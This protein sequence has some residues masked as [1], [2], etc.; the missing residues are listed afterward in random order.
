M[1]NLID[2]CIDSRLYK[3]LMRIE[4]TLIHNV[5]QCSDLFRRAMS[6]IAQMWGMRGLKA[7]LQSENIRNEL[8]DMLQH[9][10][11]FLTF[12]EDAF[13]GVNVTCKLKMGLIGGM[14][15]EIEMAGGLED[16]T[17]V[18]AQWDYRAGLKP[19]WSHQRK[20]EFTLFC[21]IAVETT[22]VG[23]IYVNDYY[24]KLLFR[25]NSTLSEAMNDNPLYK[26]H[27]DML[28]NILRNTR[29]KK[30]TNLMRFQDLYH[31]QELTR[32][33]KIAQYVVLLNT[34]VGETLL[35]PEDAWMHVFPEAITTP[36][37]AIPAAAVETSETDLE[38]L[39]KTV[40]AVSDRAITTPYIAISG[41]DP[42]TTLQDAAAE[43][44]MICEHIGL[45]YSIGM[46]D[47]GL[48]REFW[49]SHREGVQHTI[50]THVVELD[51]PNTFREFPNAGEF[52]LIYTAYGGKRIHKLCSSMCPNRCDGTKRMEYTI[53]PTELDP[54]QVSQCIP[55]LYMRGCPS[56]ATTLVLMHSTL[57][58]Y[59]NWVSVTK[60]MRPMMVLT[61]LWEG[62]VCSPRSQRKGDVTQVIH[63]V[64][65]LIQND[66]KIVDITNQLRQSMGYNHYNGVNIA[67]F[68]WTCDTDNKS[69]QHPIPIDS[70]PFQEQRVIIIRGI[71]PDCQTTL[72]LMTVA[73]SYINLKSVISV[74]WSVLNPVHG[75]FL[76]LM[77]ENVL[78]RGLDASDARL[79][80]FSVCDSFGSTLTIRDEQ[81][82]G[83]AE[84]KHKHSQICSI[85]AYNERNNQLVVKDR[86]TPVK[87]RYTE[88]VKFSPE[89]SK[90]QIQVAELTQVATV[91]VKKVEQMELTVAENQKGLGAMGDV[92][93]KINND[94]T[95][96]HN[97]IAS[98]SERLNQV[99]TQSNQLSDSL[100][101][102][103]DNQ[104][105]MMTNFF[106]QL[107][108]QSD[109]EQLR[110]DEL[111]RIIESNAR[112]NDRKVSAR[113]ASKRRERVRRSAGGIIL[114]SETDSIASTVVE[115]RQPA[116]RCDD[117][118][119]M[120]E[121]DAESR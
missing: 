98:L 27:F 55:L 54:D 60:L 34:A 88:V 79:R 26:R 23:A 52:F 94:L 119:S 29:I 4:S 64:L 17:M 30:P 115:M 13:R 61:S 89:M 101:V 16:E 92:V 20:F 93:A 85:P 31:N 75:H 38:K 1:R 14:E 44:C 102:Q 95:L 22:E 39:T 68:R 66:D 3:E 32:E 46:I 10:T 40:S 11:G 56:N 69:L 57:E 71:K 120:T 84:M 21:I 65:F 7:N 53:Q 108:K 78:I 8:Y 36:A 48:R 82:P 37:V 47:M 109:R 107:N 6:L 118:S 100:K 74:H 103:A 116:R 80:Q 97:N 49:L 43:I 72:L 18:G 15:N 12:P 87:N 63:R 62:R 35:L 2:S 51:Y 113:P 50:G 76:V 117:L 42:C 121:S 106:A 67:G 25:S 114:D 99:A 41:F 45:P 33:E 105:M 90:L 73:G 91:A 110:N 58:R 112:M 81:L 24:S 104:A 19:E 96:N 111:Q 83:I 70:Y 28:P 86:R 9:N 5:W 59:I 77:G